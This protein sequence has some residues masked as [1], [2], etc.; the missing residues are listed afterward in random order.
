MQK[1]VDVVIIGAGT[2]GLSA[3][4]QV[5]RSGKSFL[6]IDGGK[7]G[8]TCARVGC[9]PSKTL[10]HTS[11]ALHSRHGFSRL[12]IRGGEHLSIDIESALKHIRSLRDYF[13]SFILDDIKHLEDNFVDGYAK[14]R[15]RNHIIVDDALIEFDSA[16]IA[17]GTSPVIPEDWKPYKDNIIT[18]DEI[19]ELNSLP[20]SIAVIGL[21]A[22]GLELGQALHR[23]GV[24][25][26][27]F[28]RSQ[29]IGGIQDKKINLIAVEIFG[30][31]FELNIEQDLTVEK[32]DDNLLLSTETRTIEVELALISAGRKPNL[33]QL[34]IQNLQIDLD[35][36][37]L[38]MFDVETMQIEDTNIFIAGDVNKY[39]PVLHEASDEG[40][41]AGYNACVNDPKSFR[42]KV[43][44]SIIFSEPNIISIGS[45]IKEKID[46]TNIVI[47]EAEF[48]ET[49]RP[50]I[51]GKDKGI[52]RVFA[53]KNSG[54]LV[55]STMIGPEGEHI[56]HLLV[57]A[58]TQGMTVEQTLNMPFYHPVV[59][60]FIYT[61][62]KN[63]LK[64][65]KSEKIPVLGLEI[66]N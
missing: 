29:K 49:G 24:K 51:L 54:K 43:P 10:L 27:A 3:L 45:N 65:T 60:E 22:I 17:T 46:D 13:V 62:L 41:I 59:E 37:G 2:A 7:L 5:K 23:L 58:I 16:I 33:D 12:G 44:F 26:H 42:R 21:G 47:G 66:M 61:A 56:A 9:M 35:K 50:L 30:D 52:L 4:S 18:T 40:K 55:A 19:F 8:T 28:N 64:K 14:F 38:P 6:L 11:N 20:K 48:E 57:W 32:Q 34:D 1:K 15:D 36:N 31:E 53:E 25:V 39:T 63:L